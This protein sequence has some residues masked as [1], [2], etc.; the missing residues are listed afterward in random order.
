MPLIADFKNV[1]SGGGRVR[2]PEGDYR[3]K[4]LK[5]VVGESKSSGNPMITWTFE[6]IEGKLKGKKLKD[7]TTL[8]ADS[9]WKLKGLLEALGFSIPAKKVDLDKYLK[10]TI[11]KELGLTIV[12][13]EYENKMSSKIADYMTSDALGDSDEDDES[14]DDE[15]D[16]ESDDEDEEPQPK[17]KA[18]KSKKKKSSDD[19][20]D[21]IED[22]DLDEL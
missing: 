13:E 14:D 1:E 22:L 4:V 8:T 2:V 21:E 11:G 12:D 3:A 20:D 15:E 6:G 17:K 10:R 16:D 19:D 5:Y 18:K 9:L 7:Y